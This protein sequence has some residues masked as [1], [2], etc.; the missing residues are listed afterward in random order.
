MQS[1]NNA[2]DPS[3]FQHALGEAR[4]R[5]VATFPAQ[6]D[7]LLQLV[8]RIE[9]LGP[10]GSASELAQAIHR[11]GGLAGSVGFPTVSARATELENLAEA[12]AGTGTF[13]A[14]R[15]RVI[16]DAIHEAFTEDLASQATGAELIGPPPSSSPI[17]APAPDQVPVPAPAPAPAVLPHTPGAAILV[18]E[19]PVE[20]FANVATSLAEAGYAPIIVASGDLV[21]G[22][23]RAQKPALMLLDI[24]MPGLDGFSTCRQ[25][26]ADP[27]LAGIPVILVTAGVNVEDTL[28]GLALGADEILSKPLDMRELTLRIELLL[29]RCREQGRLP[30]GETAVAPVATVL[31]ADDDPD[32]TRIIDAQVRAAGYNTIVAFDGEQALAAMRAS[33]APVD[34][35]VLDLMM[36]KLNGF[37]VLAEIREGPP[38]RPRTIILSGREREQDVVRAFEHGADDYMTKPFNPQELLARIARLL[39]IDAALEP[40]TLNQ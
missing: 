24:A 6:C 20:G 11:L 26:K 13:E 25:L 32:V 3:A 16:I 27:E 21:L 4:L 37:D 34:V 2:N 19:N 15:A 35:L 40:S 39:K 38:P 1:P 10:D 7:A 33:E 14:L 31:I 36:P 18:A 22:I 17:P 29:H 23:A 9:A 28:T 12:A 30:H 8:D 5:F